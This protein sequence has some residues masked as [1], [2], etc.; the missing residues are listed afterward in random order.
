MK[1][2]LIGILLSYVLLVAGCSGQFAAGAATGAVV[3]AVKEALVER[4]AELELRHRLALDRYEAAIS[5]TEKAAVAI[6]ISRIEKERQETQ[7]AKTAIETGEVIVKTDWTTPAGA[8]STA[9][10]ITNI[11][12][13]LYYRRKDEKAKKST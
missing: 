2:V 11:L 1:K 13:A 5:E 4:E 3:T 9:A 6:E 12:T 8:A 7:T 10:L